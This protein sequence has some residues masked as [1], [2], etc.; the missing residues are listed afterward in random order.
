MSEPQQVYSSDGRRGVI[1]GD[2]VPSRDDPRFVEVQMEDGT[3]LHVPAELLVLRPD[4][5]FDLNVA[6]TTMEG[7]ATKP[8]DTAVLDRT[9][10]V[11]A[12]TQPAVLPVVVEELEVGR[13]TVTTGVVRVRKEVREREELVDETITREDVHIER[14]PVGQM[15]DVPPGVRNEGETL[16]IPILEEVLV[17]EKRLRLKEEVRVTWRRVAEPVQQRVM[18]RDEQVVVE[19]SPSMEGS[20]PEGQEPRQTAD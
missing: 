10:G 3:L 17:V 2:S 18:L 7:L 13:R 16:V 1:I 14:V 4:G 6:V 12:G 8:R 9:V 11:E 20:V 19:R 5:A 15:I